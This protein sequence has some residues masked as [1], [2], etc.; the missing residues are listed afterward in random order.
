MALRNEATVCIS[1]C[2]RRPS[3]LSAS[4]V[5]HLTKS[6]NKYRTKETQENANGVRK[7]EY[8]NAMDWL[9]SDK[10]SSFGRDRPHISVLHRPFCFRQGKVHRNNSL[11]SKYVSTPEGWSE[12]DVENSLDFDDKGNLQL[13]V[14]PKYF[15]T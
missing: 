10:I 3:S 8:I 6:T 12:N 7:Q 4:L 13:I 9:R 11:L 1:V 2:V 15:F 5:A 14:I